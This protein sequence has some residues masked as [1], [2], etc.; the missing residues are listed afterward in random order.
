MESISPVTTN[1]QVEST[2]GVT[3]SS[4]ATTKSTI[5]AARS[6]FSTFLN[7]VLAQG[8]NKSVSEE[9]LFAS[10][11]RERVS[12]TKGDTALA[13]YDAALE[14]SRAALTKPDGYVPHEDA[15]KN[16]LS[17]LVNSGTLTAAEGDN[18]YA[19]AFQAAQ[20]DSNT[21]ALWDDRGGANDPTRAVEEMEAALTAAKLAIDNL[22]SGVTALNARSLSEASSGKI[23]Y[24]G[25]ATLG[26]SSATTTAAAADVNVPNGN[27]FD[28]SG[29]FLFKPISNN[30]G[31][32]A[33]ILPQ[34][35]QYQVASVMLKDSTGTVLDEGKSTGYG[36]FGTNEKFSFSKKG[37][38]YPKDVSVEVTLASGRV[39][40]YSIPD[41]SQRYD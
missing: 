25:A 39:I 22:A 31:T 37:G 4:D 7:A 29:E 26:A 40:T 20:L 11:L 14:E 23:S 10:L 35:F 3:Q 34:Q 2:Q 9:E 12:A 17:I 28:G 32:L 16:A 19:Q 8:G 15:A 41:P 36:D 30:Q 6:D 24:T 1:K 5:T 27:H 33:V 13:E 21:T 18:L 38:S